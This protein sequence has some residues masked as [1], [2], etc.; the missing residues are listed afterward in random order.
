MKNTS[1][2][3]AVG[4]I[5]VGVYVFLPDLIPGPIDDIVLVVAYAK[6]DEIKK[7]LGAK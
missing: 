2:W 3:R 5:L 6:L 4:W 1:F 7:Y